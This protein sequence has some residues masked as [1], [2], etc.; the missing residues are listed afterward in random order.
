MEPPERLDDDDLRLLTEVVEP[1]RERL[2][3]TSGVSSS[4]LGS[5]DLR[6]GGFGFL[7]GDGWLEAGAEDCDTSTAAGEAT[8]FFARRPMQKIL[9]APR[10]ARLSRNL[11]TASSACSPD[12]YL[13][14]M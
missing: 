2:P 1:E 10:S 4:W 14:L 9:R 3:R 5:R 12:A 6:R 7:R 11:R 8:A 13:R